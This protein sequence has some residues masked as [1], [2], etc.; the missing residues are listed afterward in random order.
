MNFLRY[1]SVSQNMCQGL[2]TQ[3]HKILNLSIDI[4][5]PI[6]DRL[7]PHKNILVRSALQLHYCSG[8]K[9]L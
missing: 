9:I 2:Y 6:H 3:A 4:L 8:I 7:L 5:A 1:T